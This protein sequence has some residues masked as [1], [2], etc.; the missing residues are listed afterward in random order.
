MTEQEYLEEKTAKRRALM[1]KEDIKE[2]DKSFKFKNLKLLYRGS[3]DGDRT[4]TC[5]QLCDNKQNVLIIMQSDTGH[6]FGGYSKIG[7]KV[8]NNC[9]Y[10]I[11]V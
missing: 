4:K 2:A 11:N 7:F 5:H 9:D 8:N 1:S 3:R 6:I 10:K